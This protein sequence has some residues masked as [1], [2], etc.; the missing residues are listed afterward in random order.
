MDIIQWKLPIIIIIIIII[1]IISSIIIISIII[2]IIIIIIIIITI[3]III[4]I[5]YTLVFRNSLHLYLGGPGLLLNLG[6]PSLAK[7][8][9]LFSYIIFS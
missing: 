2:T 7:F 1:T 6:N 4:I 5:G 8:V 9:N 3:I